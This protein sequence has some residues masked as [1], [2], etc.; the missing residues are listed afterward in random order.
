MQSAL[1][2]LATLLAGANACANYNKCHCT[3][4]DGSANDTITAVV[5]N[6]S[7]KLAPSSPGWPL[8]SEDED[9]VMKCV[10]NTGPHN[11]F[12]GIDNC[13]FREFC[14]KAGATGSDS[15]CEVNRKD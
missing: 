8:Y 6:N 15:F 9:S 4:A 13:K 2:L 14:T 5:C 7:N 12:V 1:V 10:L 3:N 11:D